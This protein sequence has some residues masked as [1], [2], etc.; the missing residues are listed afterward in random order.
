MKYLA[1]ILLLCSPFL[2]QF[3]P[4]KTDTY[5]LTVTVSNL[6]STDGSV[7]VAL[8][9]EEDEFPDGTPFMAQEVSISRNGTVEVV[10]EDVPEGD[11]AVAVMHDANDNGDMDFNEYGMPIEGFGFSNDAMGD[12]GPPDFDQAAFSMDDD[13]EIE[14]NLVYMGG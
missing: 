8:H 2:T 6:N 7:G 10:F 11:Y 3:N 14:V 12:M 9:S 5:T 13:R 1:A 4:S